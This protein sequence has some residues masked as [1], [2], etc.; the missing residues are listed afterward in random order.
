M[1][2]FVIWKA[3]TLGHFH[4]LHF[5]SNFSLSP[6]F[7]R[8]LQKLA[9]VG[10][11]Q[12][13]P[14]ATFHQPVYPS[15][16]HASPR[17]RPGFF[18]LPVVP[19]S[20]SVQHRGWLRQQTHHSQDTHA[21]LSAG[22]AGPERVGRLTLCP[23]NVSRHRQRRHENETME[24][25]FG[26]NVLCDFVFLLQGCWIGGVVV[27]FG[28]RVREFAPWHHNIAIQWLSFAL[29][30]FTLLV[31]ILP[32]T[33]GQ[34]LLL[35]STGHCACKLYRQAASQNLQ[36]WKQGNVRCQ[37]AKCV[38]FTADRGDNSTL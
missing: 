25:H 19:L 27:F 29:F 9:I 11:A 30:F 32:S 14:P 31:K 28:G 38:F 17:H 35:S 22:Q 15:S 34:L 7:H 13:T 5:I 4:L 33:N 6:W 18:P 2:R 1:L 20:C 8:L 12:A 23:R 36:Q 26:L 16:H 21:A 3:L 24:W 37:S 10:A